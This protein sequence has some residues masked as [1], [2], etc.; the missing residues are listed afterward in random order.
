MAVSGAANAEEG[1]ERLQ[2]DQLVQVVRGNCYREKVP[3][4][5]GEGYEEIR[6]P[7]LAWAPVGRY[8]NFFSLRAND[9]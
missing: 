8:T 4:L 3:L 6:G 5:D 2:T 9:F 1:G 7:A